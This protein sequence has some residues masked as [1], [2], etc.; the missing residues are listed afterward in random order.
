MSETMVTVVVPIYNM[1]KYLK[2]CLDSIVNQTFRSFAVLMV[3]DGS[4]DSSYSIAKVYEEKYGFELVR[5]ENKGLGGARN[6]GIE[7]A[8]SKY[9]VFPDSD[10]W[11]QPN[12][13]EKLVSTAEKFHADVVWCGA[14]YVWDNG[15]RKRRKLSNMK[16]FQK[17]DKTELL[18]IIDYAT[19]DKIYKKELFDG[20]R[21]PE[22]MSKQDYACIPRII[23]KAEVIIGIDDSLYNYYYRLDSATNAKKVQMNLLKAQHIL[24]AS[25]MLDNHKDV[26]SSYFIRNI[27]CTL[28][29]EMIVD[30]AQYQ[31]EIGKIM[32]EGTKIYTNLSGAIKPTNIE[33]IRKPFAYLICK[34]QYSAAELYVRV[35]KAAQMVY[36]RI[37]K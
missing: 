16:S 36:H 34:K 4:T 17:I 23:A 12:Y 31:E 5:Q 19:W 13:L 33:R 37:R 14:D 22:H 20:I 32:D 6:T 35:Y 21:F 28:I 27:V 26:L 24:E 3:D 29:W 10:D 1:E 15:T 9:I 2:R 7:L 30:R 8:K 25:E 11:L 18:R